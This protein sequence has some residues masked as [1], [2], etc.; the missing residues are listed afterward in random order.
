MGS[1]VLKG[2]PQKPRLFVVCAARARLHCSCAVKCAVKNIFQ[3]DITLCVLESQHSLKKSPVNHFD[4]TVVSTCKLLRM[5]NAKLYI[6]A[7]SVFFKNY[8]I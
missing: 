5:L 4:F 6:E 2:D 8:D 7:T 3:S 1:P